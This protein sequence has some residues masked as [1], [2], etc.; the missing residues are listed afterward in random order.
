MPYPSF[1]RFFS[2]DLAID[3]G[4]ANTLVFTRDRG[5]VVREPSVV[6]INKLTNK[7]E[8]VGNEAKEML[9][10][11][12][13]N[14]Q[15]VRPMK[16]GVIADFDITEQMLKY[17]IAKAHGGRRWV[18]P[19]IVI[20]VPSEITPVEKRAVRDSAE[21]A[22]ASEVY[23]VEQAMMAAIG[24]GLPIT[25]PSGNMIVD[26]GGGTTDIAVISLAGAVYSRSLK[27]AGNELDE[28]IINYLKRRHNLLI[29][30]RTAERI[31]LELGS[32]FPLKDELR[33]EIKGRDLVEGVPKTLSITDSE[34]RES[35][36]EPVASV[37]DSVRQALERT[38][39]ELS[40]D[41]MDK[42]IV[43]S[44]GGAL[45]R[46]L[47]QRL[48]EETGLPVVQADDPLCSVVLGTGRVL[49]DMELLR[50]VSLR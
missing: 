4:T 34:V 28:A 23:L 11:T 6:V 13:G 40:A 18:R 48:R 22:G 7:I 35:L 2:D 39:P 14:I 50:K 27:V 47:D 33:M 21:Q 31:K 38:P 8:A 17:F 29:G 45:I 12:P 10:R 20:G 25:E 49:E 32:A 37:V 9:G 36:A 3:L 5:I 30:E 46:N 42:G 26:I 15:S 43:L 44:G 24:A 19:R 16:D 41:I 1:L